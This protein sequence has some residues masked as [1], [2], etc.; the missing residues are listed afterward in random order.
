MQE[1]QQKLNWK[2]EVNQKANGK[3]MDE[4]EDFLHQIRTKVSR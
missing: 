3:G 1:D 2:K 4:K